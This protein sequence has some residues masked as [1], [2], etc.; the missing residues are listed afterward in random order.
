MHNLWSKTNLNRLKIETFKRKVRIPSKF[1]CLSY[2]LFLSRF[3]FNMQSSIRNYLERW[4]QRAT[5]RCLYL[6]PNLLLFFYPVRICLWIIIV[7]VYPIRNKSDDPN[8]IKWKWKADLLLIYVNN[9]SVCTNSQ[10]C[11]HLWF[12]FMRASFIYWLPVLQH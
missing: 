6:W 3:N 4:C 10:K 7:Y 8:I 12:Y 9:M 11:H 2:F 5:C 1:K